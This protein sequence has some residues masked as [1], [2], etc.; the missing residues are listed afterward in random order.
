[1]PSETEPAEDL[2]E[3]ITELAESIGPCGSSFPER[4]GEAKRGKSLGMKL[5]RR[6]K[7]KG[8]K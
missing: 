2:V 4:D 6:K 3:L 8:G 1:M 5:R 7:S